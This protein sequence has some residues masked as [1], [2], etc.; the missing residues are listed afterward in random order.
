MQK[1]HS[2]WS[3]HLVHYPVKSKNNFSGY[4]TKF[5]SIDVT[6]ISIF[7]TKFN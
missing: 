5:N 6:G 1:L 4:I 2:P 7:K 3:L